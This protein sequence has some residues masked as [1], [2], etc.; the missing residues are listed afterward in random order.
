MHISVILGHPEKGSFNHAIADTVVG[1]LRSSG[2]G[3]FFHDLYAEQFDP[4]LPSIEIARDAYLDP[5]IKQHCDELAG[6]D[7]IVI[8]HPNWWG[9]PPAILKGWV[10]RIIRPGVAYEFAEGDGGEGVPV[11]LLKAQTALVFNTSNTPR[12]RELEVFGD[13]LEALW[14][15][16]I[17]D[18]CG[19]RN[20]YRK[21][22]EVVV[23]STFE[24]RRGWLE[25]VRETVNKYF[26]K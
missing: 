11:G 1:T 26:S 9:Q 2:H 22:Y 14:K 19:V 12:Q 18:L 16:C 13:P 4:I 3:V 20:F 15:N 21:M 23:T 6:A 7:G 25:D 17:F 8:I 5:V 10:D 24:Q